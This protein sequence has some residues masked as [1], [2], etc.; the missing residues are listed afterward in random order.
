MNQIS[1]EPSTSVQPDL[2]WSQVRET[3]RMLFLAVAQIEIAM[4]ESD[5]SVDQLTNTFTRMV[6]FEK[7]ICKAVEA[8]PDSEETRALRNTIR[9]NA[10]Q[11][12]TEMQA[13]IVAFQFYDKLTQRLSHVGTALE[14]LSDLVTDNSRIYNPEE[15]RGLQPVIK[16]RYSMREEREMFDSVMSGGNLREA[17]RQYN[18]SHKNDLS[19]DVEFF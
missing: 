7:E 18:E 8:L 16:S 6:A 12:T 15:W 19:D 11:V 13:A 17:I 3:V 9:D 10:E 5:G 1:K 14:E 4:T 2:D